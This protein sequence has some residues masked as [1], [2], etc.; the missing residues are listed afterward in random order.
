M[1]QEEEG[2][3]A[4]RKE[5]REEEGKGSWR[6]GEGWCGEGVVGCGEGGVGRVGWHPFTCWP[7]IRPQ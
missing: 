2:L 4:G 3:G 5:N 6:G 7:T 1:E